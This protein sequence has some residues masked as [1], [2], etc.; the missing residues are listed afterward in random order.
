MVQ[1]LRL[2][3]QWDLLSRLVT[4]IAH[5]VTP[6]ISIINLL[7]KS[8]DPPSSAGNQNENHNDKNSSNIINYSSNGFG[9]TFKIHGCR[10]AVSSM[11]RQSSLS[12]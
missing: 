10:R 8:P 7:T 5:I 1:G 11:K 4:H 6:V 3:D 9:Q 12:M 2:E